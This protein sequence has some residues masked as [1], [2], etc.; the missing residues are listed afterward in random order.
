MRKNQKEKADKAQVLKHLKEIELQQQEQARISGEQNV[1][2]DDIKERIMSKYDPA[3]L[4]DDDEG[5]KRRAVDRQSMMML[6]ANK[7]F[8]K[9]RSRNVKDNYLM[10]D[11]EI[12]QKLATINLFTKFDFDGSGALDVQELT[13]L[14]NENGIKVDEDDVKMLYADEKV[15]FTL[16]SFESM[17]K[18]TIKLRDFRK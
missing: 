4:V 13:A 17:N 5:E 6:Q 2:Q 3:D 8:F 15:L 11:D 1:L 14:Y 10:T 7:K 18:D 9:R 12:Q 16:D